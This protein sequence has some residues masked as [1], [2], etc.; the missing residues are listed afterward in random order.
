M[1][2]M[3]TLILS[4]MKDYY[5]TGNKFVKTGKLLLKPQRGCNTLDIFV[6]CLIPLSR[7]TVP[8]TAVTPY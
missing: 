4:I 8:N 5:N 3:D 1:K 2:I 7:C 6:S